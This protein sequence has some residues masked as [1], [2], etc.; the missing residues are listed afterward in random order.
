MLAFLIGM[1]A[2]GAGFAPSASSFRHDAETGAGRR[3]DFFAWL[4]ALT[5]ASASSRIVLPERRRWHRSPRC[6]DAH[7]VNLDVLVVKL[8]AS[9]PSCAVP[10][11][12]GGRCCL[13]RVY[14][15]DV[16]RVPQVEWS[17]DDIPLCA[18]SGTNEGQTAM[19]ECC[20]EQGTKKL[21]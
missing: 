17:E 19:K 15:R 21:H 1:T 18:N 9:Y 12:A 6:P 5:G 3:S 2:T 13:V 16:R 4:E 20:G 14:D 8:K 11:I 7:L 10:R